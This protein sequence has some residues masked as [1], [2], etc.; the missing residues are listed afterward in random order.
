M[1]SPGWR[2]TVTVYWPESLDG[3][4]VWHRETVGDAFFKR[5]DG[6]STGAE[7]TRETTHVCRI[8]PVAFP[9]VERSIVALGE[10]GD[11]QDTAAHTLE[12]LKPNAFR[13]REVADNTAFHPPH[14]R[15]T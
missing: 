2:Q 10:H 11:M 12:E 15:L 9:V 7:K 8:P 3:G 5:A 13:V 6:V 4:E 1:T 14:W